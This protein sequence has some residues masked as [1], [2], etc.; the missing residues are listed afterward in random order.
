MT[1]Q[2]C[3]FLHFVYDFMYLTS[4][5]VDLLQTQTIAKLILDM[6]QQSTRY[7]FL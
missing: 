7:Y 5:Q 3:V 6:T 2:M 4:L 1:L